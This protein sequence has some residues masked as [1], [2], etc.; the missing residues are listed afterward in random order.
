MAPFNPARL[1]LA[2][3]RRGLTKT[4]LAQRAGISTR[5]LTAYERGDRPPTEST[6]QKLADAVGFPLAFLAGDDLEEP[7]LDGV[8]FRSLSSMTAGQR[9][10]AVGAA[11]IALALDDWC[12]ATSA[13]ASLGAGTMW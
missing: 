4:R 10:Q 2:R 7:S 3:R 5:L 13:C 1:D 9:D 11:A 12:W 8:S 6:V